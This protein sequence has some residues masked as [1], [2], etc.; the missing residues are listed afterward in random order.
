MS[1]PES[2]I[3]AAL[4]ARA[5]VVEAALPYPFLWPQNGGDLPEAEHIRVSYVPNDNVPL[6]LCSDVMDRKGFLYLTLVSHLGQYEVVTRRKAGE[7][8]AYFRRGQRLQQNSTKVTI[9]GHTV[10]PGRQEGGRWETPIRISYW[11]MA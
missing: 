3:H 6:D 1:N 5:Q 11:S 10:R 2:D 9:T 8:A 4:M 7:I